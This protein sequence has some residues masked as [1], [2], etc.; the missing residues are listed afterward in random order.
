MVRD[1]ATGKSAIVGA[2]PSAA[3]EDTCRAG[4][5]E[6]AP[7]TT[8]A[9]TTAPTA[10]RERPATKTSGR[11]RSGASTSRAAATTNMHGPRST[12]ALEVTNDQAPPHGP[13]AACR[14]N[15]AAW[16]SSIVIPAVA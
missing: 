1:D 16:P 9:I 13:F 8:T 14:T 5:Q 2:V 4:A 10:S 11:L 6:A 15:H 12:A 3:G 7:S